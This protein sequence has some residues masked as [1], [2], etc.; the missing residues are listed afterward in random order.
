MNGD[1]KT[2]ILDI[3]STIGH[4]DLPIQETTVAGQHIFSIQVPESD[5]TSFAGNPDVINALDH[6]VKKIVEKNS[7]SPTAPGTED[8]FS[9]MIDIDGKR[10]AQIKDLESRA[11][12]MADRARA[13][14]Y[15]VE[16]APMSAY[17]RL[18]VH[19]TLQGS[20][21]VKTES[22]GD[23]FNRRVVIKYVA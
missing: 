5:M 16:L 2:I 23:G 10:V 11:I 7:A 22:Q 12:M 13:F 3:F 18:I 4:T 6:L 17:E 14:Q 19:T 20:P 8:R 1:V 15:D 21:Q 9:F